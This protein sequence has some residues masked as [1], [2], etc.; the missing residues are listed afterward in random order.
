MDKGR[1][2]VHMKLHRD[3]KLFDCKYCGSYFLHRFTLHTHLRGFEKA[4]NDRHKCSKCDSVFV[5]RTCYLFH[6]TCHDNLHHCPTCEMIFKFSYQLNSHVKKKH[7]GSLRTHCPHC[8]NEFKD[9]KVLQTHI[10]KV[11]YKV[12]CK[13]CNAAFTDEVQRNRHA[14]RMHS[15]KPLERERPF[16]C[17]ICQMTLTAQA[18]LTRHYR[19]S[20]NMDPPTS[21]NKEN[22]IDNQPSPKKVVKPET[23]TR[24]KTFN[25]ELY[26]MAKKLKTRKINQ[27]KRKIQNSKPP[28]AAKAIDKCTCLNCGILFANESNM[29]RHMVQ[30]CQFTIVRTDV[31]LPAVVCPV[32]VC[33]QCQGV[34]KNE[35]GLSRHILLVHA[36]K[37]DKKYPCPDCDRS[38]T[39]SGNLERHKRN[40]HTA[41]KL[42]LKTKKK[43]KKLYYSRL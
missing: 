7:S 25:S 33:P 8:N 21:P 4:P 18:Y 16:R 13:Y 26:R 15:E 23:V 37:S 20:H 11:H 24:K 10:S 41:R 14:A 6:L 32:V 12:I 17:T 22:P 43:K 28:T 9:S 3:G 42:S 38:Y 30:N 19:K 35:N 34:F 27:V 5:N 1:Y 36:K 2:D 31:V 40:S 29:R 39:Q